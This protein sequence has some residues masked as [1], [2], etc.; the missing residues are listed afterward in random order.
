MAVTRTSD[1]SIYIPLSQRS[2]EI[3]QIDII[4]GETIFIVYNSSYM[5]YVQG[6]PRRTEKTTFCMMKKVPDVNPCILCEDVHERLANM[7]ID[8]TEECA[9]KVIEKIQF[10][11]DKVMKLYK[12]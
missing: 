12:E 9:S 10:E 1:I 2:Q 7:E 3:D 8:W 4:F 5:S 11:I 6:V